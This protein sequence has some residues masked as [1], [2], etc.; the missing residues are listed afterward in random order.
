MSET[1][2]RKYTAFTQENQGPQSYRILL[3]SKINPHLQV[4]T[5]F[6]CGM[7]VF[8]AV[9]DSPIALDL[10][11]SVKRLVSLLVIHIHEK[12]EVSHSKSVP[13]EWKRCSCR[14]RESLSLKKVNE[15]NLEG[16]MRGEVF[17][18]VRWKVSEL[19]SM[20]TV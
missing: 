18:R 13:F 15:R 5:F 17:K 12:C 16:E 11:S 19:V 4:W 14:M 2:L 9:L 20:N 10:Y 7:N 1:W 8:F 6:V 3:H